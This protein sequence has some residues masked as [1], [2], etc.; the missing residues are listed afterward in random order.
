[1]PS[2]DVQTIWT[3]GSYVYEQ[4]LPTDGFDIKVYTIGKNYSYAEAWRSPTLGE[5][6]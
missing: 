4:F 6:V 5:K 1:M 2:L 3:E